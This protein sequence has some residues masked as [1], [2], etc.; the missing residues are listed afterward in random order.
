MTQ[1]NL[2][3]DA[4]RAM[5]RDS[6]RGFLA[7]HWPAAKAVEWA[8]DPARLQEAWGQLASQGLTSLGCDPGEGGLREIAIVMEEMG[9]AA[10][11]VPV[12][13]GALLN[14]AR[15][16]TPAGD[17][18]P[19]LAAMH[20]G[21]ARVVLSFGD[22]EGDRQAGGTTVAGERIRGELA[23][24]ELAGSAT[25]FAV[26]VA[27]AGSAPALA[28]VEANAPGVTIEAT[29]AMGTGGLYRVTLLDAPA[30]LLEVQA[31]TLRD[32]QSMARL[33]LCARATGAATRAFEMAVDYAKERKQFGRVIGSFQA[34]QHKLANNQIAL[35][36][37]QL[38]A[39]NAARQHDIGAANWRVFV[40]AACALAGATLRQVALETQHTFGAIGY[41]E[42]HE[43]PRHFKRVHLDVLR[44]GGARRAREELAEYFL[45]EVPNVLPEYDLGPA[46]NA[47]REEVRA[48]LKTHWSAERKAAHDRLSFKQREYDRDFAR[49]LGETGWIGLGWPR[50]FGGQERGAFEQLAFVEEMERADAPRAGAPVQSAMLQVYG[51]P[52]QQDRYLPEILRGEAI[53]G[54]GYSEPDS[55]SDLASMH[56]RA[57]R[58]GDHYVINGQKIWTTTYWGDYMLLATRTDPDA[59]PPHA[60]LSLFIVPMD[61]PGITI[62]TSTTMY[63]GSF[64]NVFYDDVRVPADA[65][66]GELNGGWKVLVGALST[67]RGFIG[68][69]IVMKVAHAF[70][71][72]CE[73]VR[74]A[75]IDGR[76]MRLDPPVRERIGDLASQIEAGR[77]MM[78]HCAEC[79]DAGETPP[80]DAAASKVYSGELMERFGETAL[81]ILGMEGTLSEGSPGAILRGRIEQNLRHSLMWVISIGTNEI[82][83]TLI[84]QRGLGLPR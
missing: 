3:S 28:L 33:A 11:P 60:G 22:F 62:K 36:G 47:F 8:T 39:S 64:A 20:A 25:H 51:T 61:T 58:D 46:G 72:L 76:A 35:Q 66:V 45:G 4:E 75:E 42:E 73:Y 44:H 54:M 68:G 43:A 40:S 26:A 18:P 77:Q 55:G 53:Y 38:T 23:Y 10:C 84:A 19:V 31:E 12:H 52:A 16:R 41:S 5:L 17:E 24:L 79:V 69:G 80:H 32:L 56:T 15:L 81:D 71:L 57:V 65:M 14:L 82:Q 30:T 50:R 29:P 49:A 2:P 21:D 74:G 34:I 70:E 78:M 67:E 9:R 37:A 83:R 7:R 1:Q 27:G 48:W 6:V 13:H 59:S 63:G